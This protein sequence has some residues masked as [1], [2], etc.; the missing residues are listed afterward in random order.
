MQALR[1]ALGMTY[2]TFSRWLAEVRSRPGAG[3]LVEA[4]V[5]MV[6]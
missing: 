3:T 6:G 2:Y 1:F 5:A 4:D